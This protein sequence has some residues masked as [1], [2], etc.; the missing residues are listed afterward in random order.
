MFNE[1]NNDG[2][3]GDN[4]GCEGVHFGAKV[5]FTSTNREPTITAVMVPCGERPKH[6]DDVHK[7]MIV[8]PEGDD[9]RGVRVTLFD[10][11]GNTYG[12]FT[13]GNP[14]NDE[15]DAKIDASWADLAS[16]VCSKARLATL[17]VRAPSLLAQRIGT[18]SAERSTVFGELMLLGGDS[19][20]LMG[21][22]EDGELVSID[23]VGSETERVYGEALD[24]VKRG[25]CDPSD[26]SIEWAMTSGETYRTAYVLDGNGSAMLMRGVAV[27]RSENN[28]PLYI[29]GA[30]NERQAKAGVIGRWRYETA[31]IGIDNEDGVDML[32]ISG[33]EVFVTDKTEVERGHRFVVPFGLWEVMAPDDEP[34]Q[35]GPLNVVSEAM[36]A[37]NAAL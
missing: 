14:P 26:E 13:P 34:E 23:D 37:Y 7:L 2:D 11:Q 16:N 5:E 9:N 36:L 15:V 17:K 20:G 4:G 12:P 3:N 29:E 27:M 28:P 33:Y 30:E 24:G 31:A 18:T 1:N 8:E 10:R 32:V 35:R 25:A 22:N 6:L 19:I 21:G